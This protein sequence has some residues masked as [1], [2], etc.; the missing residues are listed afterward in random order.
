[1]FGPKH[2]YVGEIPLQ[3]L[4][5]HLKLVH[6]TLAVKITLLN[7]RDPTLSDLSAVIVELSHNK[8]IG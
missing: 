4:K 1:M 3:L 6:H 7:F 5:W 2:I 8:K